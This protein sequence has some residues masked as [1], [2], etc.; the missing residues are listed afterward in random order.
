[1]PRA[2]ERCRGTTLVHKVTEEGRSG[3][4]SADLCYFCRGAWAA[5]CADLLRN[6]F[7]YADP[8]YGAGF[9]INVDLVREALNNLRRDRGR[10]R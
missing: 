7:L 5:R 1:M 2:C 3:A 8:Y 4:F 6:P 9:D 10:K